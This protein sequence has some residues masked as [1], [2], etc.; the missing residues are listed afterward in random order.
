MKKKKTATSKLIAKSI[1]II[2]IVKNNSSNLSSAAYSAY[3]KYH[4]S[5]FRLILNFLPARWVIKVVNATILMELNGIKIAATTGFK[6]PVT[7][8]LTPIKL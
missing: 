6:C 4:F 1:Y 2:V 7:A 8:K 3:D 5:L